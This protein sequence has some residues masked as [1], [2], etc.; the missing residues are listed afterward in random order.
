MQ[1]RRD[2]PVAID[3]T[4]ELAGTMPSKR[5]IEVAFPLEQV[6]LDSVHE[7]NVRHGHISTLHIW[8]ARRPLAASRAAL[9]A[10]L[11]PDPG[12][13]QERQAIYRR[14]AGKVIET[15]E[16]EHVDGRTV[17]RRKRETQGG[18]LHWKRENGQDLDWFRARIRD[19]Y[20]GRAP[21]VLDPFAGGGAIPLEANATRLRRHGRRHQSGRLV[22]SEVHA[23]L[24]PAARGRDPAVARVRT[25]GPRL[26]GRIPEGEGGEG[27]GAETRA[28]RARPRRGR[29]NH[30]TEA[31]RCQ[32]CAG[33]RSRLAGPRVG[34]ARAGRGAAAARPPLSDLRGVS[35]VEA[36][37]PAVRAAAAGAV[38]PG[39]GRQHGR[40][41]AEQ[42]ARCGLP[43]GPAESALGGN[44]YRRVSVGAH[45]PLQGVPRDDPAA[46]DPLAREEGRQARAADDGTERGEHR[47]RVR[48]R[49][50]R[51]PRGRA[52][53]RG[54]ASTTTGSAPAR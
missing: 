15:V 31:A 20:G 41:S 51:T 53:P 10:T 11:L 44:A 17:A 34:T 25:A 1:T 43:E 35:D 45:G 16:D 6:S 4:A 52:T 18:I 36:G 7:K 48:G 50:R 19:V 47:R 24:P 3:G 54:G 30:G 22:H 13:A 38:G 33:G 2:R 49:G 39:G 21:R 14:M 26:H 9:I 32:T 28:R 8:P 46:Q 37:R 40:R 23:R 5:F 27:P 29:G 12:N 42:G